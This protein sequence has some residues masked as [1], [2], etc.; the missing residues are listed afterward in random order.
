MGSPR[1]S[2]GG[3][4]SSTGSSQVN[5]NATAAAV[6]ETNLRCMLCILQ[7]RD[8]MPLHPMLQTS[9]ASE[10]P[11]R[12]APPS[13]FE[14]HRGVPRAHSAFVPT[15]PYAN[16]DSGL[17]SV[18]SAPA[19]AQGVDMRVSEDGDNQGVDSPKKAGRLQHLKMR[20][21]VSAFR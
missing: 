4:T 7:N 12:I 21:A 8:M 19:V 1:S 20:V 17:M 11:A 13:P 18:E 9:S 5:S 15:R 3:D 2:D 10:S 14:A 16:S 6:K